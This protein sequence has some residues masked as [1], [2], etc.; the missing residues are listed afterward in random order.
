M[1]SQVAVVRLFLCLMVLYL[2]GCGGTSSSTGPGSMMVTL[3]PPS[4]NVAVNA[5]VQ[6]SVQNPSSMP[7]YTSW[8][9]WSIQEYGSSTACTEVVGDPQHA[10]PL[11][12]CPSG[13]LALPMVMTGFPRSYVYYFAPSALTIAHVIADVKFYA[14]ESQTAIS[15][16]GSGTSAIT[17]TSQ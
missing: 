7:K 8:V 3:A 10:P 6:I 17:V 9:D 14:D 5:S 16:E 4:A 13:W 1:R 2:S 11:A 15:F 12:N